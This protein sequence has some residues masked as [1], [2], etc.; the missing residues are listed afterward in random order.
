VIQAIWDNGLLKLIFELLQFF[1]GYVHDYGLAIILLTVAFRVLMIPLTWKQTKSMYELQEI[2]PKIKAL[3]NKYK[4]N[5]EKQ[6][7]EL[8]K[9]YKENKVNPFG[10][11]LPL[12]LQMP[13]FIALFQV[14]REN[15]LKQIATL[16]I[17]AQAATRHFWVILPDIT[18]SPQQVYSIASTPATHTAGVA[19]GVASAVATSAV[20]PGAGGVVSGVVAILPYLFFVILFGVS[21]W[22]PQYLMT[23]DKM[24]R[25]TGM[26]M[27]IAMLYFGFIS[28]AG[29][30]I[31]WVTSS[32]WQVGQQLIT[33]RIM[34]K[35]KEAEA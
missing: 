34:D 27:A 16:P 21:V 14:L 4:N 11:C 5:K 13:L 28:P 29:V 17:A 1:Y 20:L 2:Q 31:Y 18:L 35:A 24:Q 22:L 30:L 12:L 6:Q 19:T 26:Y 23:T 7:E 25:R 33:K 32:A 8:M 3:Q 9:F 10:G 15:L